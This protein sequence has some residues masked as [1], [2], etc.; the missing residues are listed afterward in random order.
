MTPALVAL[1]QS[2]NRALAV[3]RTIGGRPWVGLRLHLG[4]DYLL[5]RPLVA[6]AALLACLRREHRTHR[7]CL[8]REYQA[9]LNAERLHHLTLDLGSLR[10]RY[11]LAVLRDDRGIGRVAAALL[12]ELR[13]LAARAAA[14]GAA[15]DVG[16]PDVHVFASVHWCPAELPHPSVVMVHDVIPLLLPERFPREVDDWREVYLPIIRQADR[17][18]TV[19]HHSAAGIARHLGIPSEQIRVIHNGVS[20]LPVGSR[21]GVLLPASPYLVY[22]GAYDAHKNLEVVLD[23]LCDPQLEGLALVL[24]GGNR[25][26]RRR[27]AERGLGRRVWFLG[28][29]SDPQVGHVLAHSVALVLP[30]LAEGFGLPPL[31][32]AM[33][34]VPSVCSRRP[35]MTE[36]LGPE[37]ALFAEPDDPAEWRQAILRLWRDAALRQRLGM[38]AQTRAEHYRWDLGAAELVEVCAALAAGVAPRNGA[39]VMAGA[40]G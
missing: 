4:Q 11:M 17:I 7:A 8:H 19:S 21:P 33:L 14:S 40:E 22:L 3:A 32:A 37:A 27:V 36:I 30:S 12:R 16:V 38:A 28:R 15:A 5:A 20:R 13:G 29:L 31:E 6:G 24:I 10:I 35:P 39:P 25:P 2:W 18:V 9:R 26:Y 34:G 1:C 23:A